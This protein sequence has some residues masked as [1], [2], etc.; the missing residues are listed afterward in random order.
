MTR[1]SRQPKAA[2][3]ALCTAGLVTSGCTFIA[4]VGGSSVIDAD[5]HGGTV[6][7]VSTFTIDGAMN[8]ATSWC[9]QYGL[10][11]VETQIAFLTDSMQFA[12]VPRPTQA[13]SGALAPIAPPPA[14][15]PTRL[16]SP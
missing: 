6:T 7:R 13:S 15:A 4:T 14:S 10:Y 5:Q 3:I 2:F 1:S 16:M 11:P 9:G 12:C 8:M